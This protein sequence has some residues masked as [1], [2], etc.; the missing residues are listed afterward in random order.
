M[1]RLLQQQHSTLESRRERRSMG[2]PGTHVVRPIHSCH[3]EPQR[4]CRGAG[5]WVITGTF[6]ICRSD[7]V[8]ATNDAW[9][10]RMQP[11]LKSCSMSSARPAALS[12]QQDS[13]TDKE[14][15]RDYFL[16]GRGR[17]REGERYASFC[18]RILYASPRATVAWR[19]EQRSLHAM[20]MVVIHSA[21]RRLTHVR[22]NRNSA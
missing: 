13:E 12:V 2:V 8:A 18:R 16:L 5:T 22:S 21:Y 19:R 3:L 4:R 11:N 7:I 20:F 6:S 1:V 9:S 14:R 10:C 15:G 17:L